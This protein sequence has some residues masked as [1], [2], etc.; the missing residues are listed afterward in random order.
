MKCGRHEKGKGTQTPL[1]RKIAKEDF[2]QNER[3]LEIIFCLKAVILLCRIRVG[4]GIG[5]AI[6][7]QGILTPGEIEDKQLSKTL[8]S[9]ASNTHSSSD[10][11]ANSLWRAFRFLWK[12]ERTQMGKNECKMGKKLKQLVFFSPCL[13]SRKFGFGF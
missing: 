4:I 6:L 8:I 3:T 9:S 12:L 7:K 5:I 13:D 11:I 2:D 10:Q 1:S